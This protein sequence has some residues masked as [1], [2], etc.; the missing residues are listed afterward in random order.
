MTK[1]ASWHRSALKRLAKTGLIGV[2]YSWGTLYVLIIQF[3]FHRRYWLF[4]TS[5]GLL[6]EPPQLDEFAAVKS[7]DR[8]IDIDDDNSGDNH[9]D[10]G[11]THMEAC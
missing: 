7:T 3:R 5:F 9:D 11:S 8:I 4:P 2:V 10:D 1:C 6:V